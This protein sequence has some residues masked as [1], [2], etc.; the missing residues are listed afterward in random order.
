MSI[1][2]E[3]EEFDT[4]LQSFED[5][6]QQIEGLILDLEAAGVRINLSQEYLPNLAESIESQ[7]TGLSLTWRSFEGRQGSLELN[8]IELTGEEDQLC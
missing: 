3:S 6:D 2:T 5:R 1:G 8:N 4:F 7:R